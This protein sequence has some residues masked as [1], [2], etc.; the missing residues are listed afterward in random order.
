MD[1]SVKCTLCYPFEGGD[2]S[3]G[4]RNVTLEDGVYYDC[5]VSC[6]TLFFSGAGTASYS[7]SMFVIAPL[8]WL[9]FTVY[10]ANN[11]VAQL[12][13][14]VWWQHQEEVA[15]MSQ[16]TKT[17]IGL[18]TTAHGYDTIAPLVHAVTITFK[19]D[20]HETHWLLDQSPLLLR[21]LLPSRLPLL[22]SKLSRL[23]QRHLLPQPRPHLAPVPPYYSTHLF[24]TLTAAA[25]RSS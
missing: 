14:G 24:H 3:A 19:T 25:S 16:S 22:P 2:V 12:I 5:S 21:N 23:L 20:R 11:E 17:R 7:L 13:D 8:M 1:P 4:C 10:Y 15:A 18:S 6:T 9:P